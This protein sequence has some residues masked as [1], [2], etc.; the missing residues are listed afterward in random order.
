MRPIS[1]IIIH[2]TATRADWWAD[3]T[4]TQKVAEVRKWHVDGRGWSDIGY[5]FLIDRDGTVAE[6]RP[7][8]RTGAHVKGHNTGTIGISLFG[9]HGGEKD[10]AFDDN[11]TE[12]QGA[13]L[14]RLIRRLHTEHGPNLKLSG[15]H[16]YAN[17]ACPC[18]DVRSWLA[19]TVSAPRTSPAQSTTLQAAAVQ[20]ATGLG[21]GG[22]AIGALDG[23]AQII[24]MVFAGVVVLA[25]LYIMRERLAKWAGG[26]R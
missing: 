25:A 24:A 11:F 26:V 15:H 19:R 23:T 10:N 17:K 12:E 5:H 18:F 14:R 8:K 6:G 4:T 21:A 20:V 9:G 22:T 7:V 1:E 13:A 3:K 16:E 2:C